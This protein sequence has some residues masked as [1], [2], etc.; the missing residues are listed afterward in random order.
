LST[1]NIKVDIG[2]NNVDGLLALDI[3][4]EYL[5]TIPAL[6]PLVMVVKAFL[7]QKNLNSAATS[8]LSSYALIC[9]AISFVQ[10]RKPRS[11][12]VFDSQN[13]HISFEV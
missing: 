1:G 12:S 7:A 4:N 3:I 10:V 2:I 11:Q 5:S 8:G 9:M 6:R 13:A